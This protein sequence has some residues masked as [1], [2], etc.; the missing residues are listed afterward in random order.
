VTVPRI[1]IAAL[2][3]CVA[4]AALEFGALRAWYG[5]ANGRNDDLAATDSP[6]TGPE[7]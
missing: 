1:P 3:A 4:V 2:M 7:N 5:L 6:A